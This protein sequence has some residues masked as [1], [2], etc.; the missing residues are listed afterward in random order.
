MLF[1]RQ[2]LTRCVHVPTVQ[3]QQTRSTIDL[4]LSR[5]LWLFSLAGLLFLLPGTARTQ[6][7]SGSVTY[8][9]NQKLINVTI[10]Y[11]AKLVFN[12]SASV[13]FYGRGSGFHCYDIDGNHGDATLRYT[14]GPEHDGSPV[15]DCYL[16]DEEGNVFYHNYQQGV[17]TVRE[18]VY[19]KPHRYTDSLSD[20]IEWTSLD[21]TKIIGDMIAL[22]AST[23][24]RGRDYTVWYTPEIPVPTGPW[25]LLGLDGLILE[26]EDDEGA[27]VFKATTIELSLSPEILSKVG[28]PVTG[29]KIAFDEFKSIYWKEQLRI[30][31]RMNAQSHNRDS[32]LNVVKLPTLERF[33]SRD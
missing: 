4:S 13:F 10:P 11:E 31:R 18:V 3:Q 24:F 21:S 15:I 28:P 22:S 33:S 32:E 9:F 27:V 14:T 7:N 26:A 1:Y 8:Q 29:K 17:I 2:L 12:D 5:I 19:F 30:N 20:R 6:D 23:T 25:K 16:A